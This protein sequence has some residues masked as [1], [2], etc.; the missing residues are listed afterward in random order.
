MTELWGISLM[1]DVDMGV[2]VW[3]LRD[4]NGFWS[5]WTRPVNASWWDSPLE[6][7]DALSRSPAPVRY[8]GRIEKAPAGLVRGVPMPIIIPLSTATGEHRADQDRR[9]AASFKVLSSR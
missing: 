7:A 3:A 6:A 4:K 1:R 9:L 8:E 5:V 2:K